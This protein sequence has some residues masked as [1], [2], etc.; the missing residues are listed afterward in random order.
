MKVSILALVIVGG[1]AAIVIFLVFNFL[2]SIPTQKYEISVDPILVKD[3]MGSETHVIIKNTGTDPLTNVK[4]DYGGTTK[5]DVIYLLNPGE[6][7]SLS[8]PEGSDLTTVRVTADQGIDITQPYRM[9][10]SAPF[11]G[12]S[13]FG[14]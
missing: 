1:L 9:P 11:V 5:P 7:I 13:G 14:G 2:V 12:N 6:K 4:V 10:A 3:I 8:P